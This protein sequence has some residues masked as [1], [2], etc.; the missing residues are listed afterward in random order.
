MLEY[1]ESWIGK[2]FDRYEYTVTRDEIV[3]FATALG[4]TN[5]LFTDEE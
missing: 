3:E 1:D 4:E 5:P 2:E